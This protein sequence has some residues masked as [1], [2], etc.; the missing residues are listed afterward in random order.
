MQILDFFQQYQR[1]IPGLGFIPYYPIQSLSMS[2]VATV[3][4]PYR[5][6]VNYAELLLVRYEY[7]TRTV[8]TFP[9]Y[10]M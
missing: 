8:F 3:R 4:V 10:P 5:T 2:Y 7:G 1:V 6:S 9:I